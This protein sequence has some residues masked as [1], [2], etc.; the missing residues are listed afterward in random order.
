MIAADAALRRAFIA[1]LIVAGMMR[2]FT[3]RCE[4]QTPPPLTSAT[5]Q[6]VELRPL[7]EAPPV[8]LERIDGKTLDLRSLRGK[9]VL[10]SFWATWCPPCRRELP[11]LER[12][13]RADAARDVE[14]VAVS[15]DQA[16]KPAVAA[17]LY[18]LGVKSLRPFLDPNGRIAGPPSGVEAAPFVLYGMPISYVIDRQGRVAGY[19]TGEVDW[20][21]DAGLALLRHYAEVE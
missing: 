20:M 12:L 17:F 16:G 19:I 7:A 10:L 15:V 21:S 14:V 18:R 13:A 6:F 11:T 5:S 4:P 3:A 2:P 1:L 9:V 8:K